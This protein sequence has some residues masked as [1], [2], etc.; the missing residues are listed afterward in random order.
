MDGFGAGDRGTEHDL[1]N[2]AN[3]DRVAAADLDGT[4]GAEP[5]FGCDPYTCNNTEYPGGSTHSVWL[6]GGSSG[7]LS[8]GSADIPGQGVALA[9]MDADGNVDVMAADGDNS[10]FYAGDGSGGGDSDSGNAT[11][12]G[13]DGDNDGGGALGSGMLVLLSLDWLIHR[14]LS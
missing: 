1:A 8:A 2:N 12:P 4:G 9:D 13:S 3:C 6:N 5:V 11:L 7:T 14:R 10:Y